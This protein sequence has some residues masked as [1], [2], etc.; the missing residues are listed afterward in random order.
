LGS[1]DGQ[2]LDQMSF[3]DK[4]K[5]AFK[6]PSLYE[7]YKGDNGKAYLGGQ[8]QAIG[9]FAGTGIDDYLK[10]NVGMDLSTLMSGGTQNPKPIAPTTPAISEPKPVAPTQSNNQVNGTQ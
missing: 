4:A 1:I 10:S 8:V 5:M 7:A 2:S 6:S 9:R 3:L